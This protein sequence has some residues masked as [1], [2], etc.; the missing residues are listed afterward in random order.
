MLDVGGSDRPQNGVACPGTNRLPWAARM[1]V[2]FLELFYY[3]AKH[4]GISAAVRHI[5]YGIQQPAVSTQV[6]KLERDLGVRLF[7]RSPFRLT[8]AG[9]VLYD[10]VAPFFEQMN[11][12][13]EKVKSAETTELR[14]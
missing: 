10:Y 12:V 8:R 7:E 14:I 2:H 11:E 13:A 6:G 9:T 1:N 5:P 4:G 3:V